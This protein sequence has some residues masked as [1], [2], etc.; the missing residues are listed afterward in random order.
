MSWKIQAAAST[1]LGFTTY[2]LV[3][4]LFT[5]SVDWVGAVGFLAGFGLGLFL[6]TKARQESDEAKQDKSDDKDAEA[7]GGDEGGQ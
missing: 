3:S 1:I 6:F 2:A 5:G 7:D 4:L